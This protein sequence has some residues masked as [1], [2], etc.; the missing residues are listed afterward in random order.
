MVDIFCYTDY[1]KFLF[2]FY[3]AKKRSTPHFSHR[4]VAQKVGFSSSGFFSKIIVT[5]QVVSS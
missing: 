2:D 1:R 5:I 3:E 4:Y